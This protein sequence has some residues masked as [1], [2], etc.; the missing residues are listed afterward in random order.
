M[1][2]ACALLSGSAIAADEA[3]QSGPYS[4]CPN[5]VDEAEQITPDFIRYFPGSG[6]W[7]FTDRDFSPLPSLSDK[8]IAELRKVV[9]AL[10]AKGVK[11]MLVVPPVRGLIGAGAAGPL[12]ERFVRS[13][14]DAIRRSYRAAIAQLASS[15]AI[16]PDVL[17]GI[18]AAKMRRSTTSIAVRTITGAQKALS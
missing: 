12:R 9:S 6:N 16:V 5:W 4:F 2:A 11:T 15:G 13:D 3:V 1:L 14:D 18:D 10:S 17:A 7:L 8:D